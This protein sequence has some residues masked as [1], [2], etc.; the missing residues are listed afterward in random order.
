M[1]KIIKKTTICLIAIIALICWMGAANAQTDSCERFY[2]ENIKPN[3][4][5]GQWAFSA[6]YN[7]AN[8]SGCILGSQDN[9][10]IS[11]I[12][13]S[14]Y[15]QPSPNRL[16]VSEK[17][18]QLFNRVLED[19]TSLS[20]G[21]CSE[22][23]PGGCLIENQIKEIEKL[24]DFL[25]SGFPENIDPILDSNN[26]AIKSDGNQIIT[27][28]NVST[29]VESQCQGNQ[30]STKCKVAILLTA[31]LI[32]SSNAMQQLVAN[33]RLPIIGQNKQ[34]LSISDKK[35]DQYFNEVSVQYPW[36]LLLNSW[37]FTKDKTKKELAGFPEPPDSRIVILH[38]SVGFEYI[39]S[40][41]KGDSLEASVLMEIAGYDFWKWKNGEAKNRWGGSVVA[42]Y[43]DI[44]G[45]DDIG[46]GVVLRTPIQNTSI[47]VVWRDGDDGSKTGVFINVD[48][49]KL[50]MQYKDKD[51]ADFLRIGR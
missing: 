11:E 1:I 3:D 36:E 44:Q 24:R 46:I 35:W 25:K 50:I 47:G 28:D 9:S 19:L 42:S 31:K 5:G 14:L 39:D 43:A 8:P 10:G 40:P 6:I 18:D 37:M 45:M 16:R 23:N 22:T 29:F 32:R 48:L 51:L 2:E 20:L 27:G 13:K 38:P 12:Y 15:T 17:Q 4:F 49:A 30:A 21:E 7:Q 34:F 26:W 41:N 33:Y